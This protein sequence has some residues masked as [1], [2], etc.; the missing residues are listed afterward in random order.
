M[1]KEKKNKKKKTN[2]CKSVATNSF[3]ENEPLPSWK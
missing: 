2:T 1:K 3:L